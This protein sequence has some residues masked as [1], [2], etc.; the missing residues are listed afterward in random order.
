MKSKLF[1][2]AVLLA[3]PV[4][5]L[6]A[7]ACG[8][9]E[10]GENKSYYLQ[11]DNIY[12]AVAA[13]YEEESR[14]AISRWENASETEKDDVAKQVAAE[15]YAY[16][17]YNEE[18]IDKY[19]YFSSQTGSTDLGSSGSGDVTTQ[20]YKLIIH[21]GE[22]TPGY[23]Y[24]YTLKK[25]NE[26]SGLL[27]TFKGSFESARLRFVA[28]TN[29]LYRFEGDDIRYET[30]AETGEATD[31]LTC[32]W[33]T[34]DDWGTDDPP[35]VKREGAKLT[36]DEIEEDI[37]SNAR[38]GYEAVIH[39]NVNVLAD[40]AVE[41]A[42]ISSSELNGHT[43]YNIKMN[44]NAEAIS[45]DEASRLMLENANSA[46]S[47][48]WVEDEE[49]NGPVLEFEIWENGL[50]K[51]YSLDETWEGNIRVLL[52]SFAGGADTETEVWYS[53]SD[54]D[55]SMTEK[56]DMLENAMETHG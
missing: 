19:V 41:S 28:D 47:C 13:A 18:Y 34:G 4:V 30:D 21:E 40:N 27:N 1:K 43:V 22:N 53:Y 36:L 17:C 54:S 6:T 48:S 2:A 52:F 26:A 49:G 45:A 33:A 9:D 24:H 15:L 11:D 14:A 51:Y 42:T 10:V 55:T 35:I 12:P 50:L 46:D 23:K 3:V 32:T 31:I 16:A 56:L 37:L 29:K 7:S 44:L 39:G 8:G 38:N 5:A 20:N 25:V